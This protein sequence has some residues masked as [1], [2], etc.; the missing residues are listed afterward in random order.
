MSQ[1]VHVAIDVHGF[2]GAFLDRK[3][4]EKQVLR[5]YPDRK[6]AIYTFD[7]NP[8]LETKE[9]Y[10][11][12]YMGCNAVAF[13]SNDEKRCEQVQKTLID[14]G[15]T[16]D[17]PIKYWRYPVGCIAENAKRHLDEAKKQDHSA[18]EKAEKKIMESTEFKEDGPIGKLIREIEAEERD[19]PL[20]IVDAIV[21][22]NAE[23]F[24][25]QLKTEAAEP[26]AP[27]PE[28]P[29]VISSAGAPS[30]KA[31]NEHEDDHLSDHETPK[32]TKSPDTIL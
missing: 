13:A 16:F 27:A 32:V 1:K 14:V 26:A 12:P 4:L 3:D 31:T 21:P 6:F 23:E 5:E 29:V 25:E 22:L 2:V 15:L 18:G 9:I 8:G 11:I 19:K 17:D 20:T 28:P 7:L 10:L 30:P 24:S